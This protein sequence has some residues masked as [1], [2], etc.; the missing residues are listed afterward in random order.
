MCEYGKCHDLWACHGLCAKC[1]DW[2]ADPSPRFM[3]KQF[4]IFLKN[5]FTI[6]YM[7]SFSLTELRPKHSSLLRGRTE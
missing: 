7:E 3:V 2:W 5:F 4:L 1:H 6:D